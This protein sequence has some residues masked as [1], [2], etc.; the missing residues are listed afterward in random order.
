MQ[1]Q[2]FMKLWTYHPITFRP[3]D[4]NVEIDPSK[5]MCWSM[6]SLR[7]RE[8]LPRLHQLLGTDQFLWCWTTK[9]DF[10]RTSKEITIMVEWE[11]DVPL[12]EIWAFYSVPIWDDIV[13]GKSEAWETLVV[14]K[15]GAVANKDLAAWIRFPLME[16][17]I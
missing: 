12:S 9:D 8:V 5:G 2:N 4:P 13:S 1:E 17:L 3:D 16:C 10:T 7:Y 14:P 11:L 15:E 6:K